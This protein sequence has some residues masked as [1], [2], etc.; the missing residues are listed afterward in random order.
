M[1]RA[2]SVDVAGVSLVAGNARLP[3]VIHNAQAVWQ[4]FNIPWPLYKGADRPLNRELVTA[5]SVLGARGMRSRCQFLPVVNADSPSSMESAFGRW[6]ACNESSH[7]VLAIGP[8]TNLARMQKRHAHLFNRISRI[9]WMGGSSGPGNH[10]E[11]AEFNA[12]VDADAALQ[13]LQGDVPVHVVDLQLCRR[14]TFSERDIPDG[15]PELFQDLMGGYL[16]I[17]LSRGR[18]VMAIYDP[19]ATLAVID[20]DSLQFES[21]GV[22]VSAADDRAYGKTDFYT[23]R[24]SSVSLA[25]GYSPD[26]AQQCL[27]LFKRGVCQ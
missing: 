5:E 9:V 11:H 15:L 23:D 8:L 22:S 7:E 24:K 13:I 27:E 10:T 20:I 12:A 26:C 25:V 2:C 17:A 14:V 18:Q 6:L 1:L 21:C 4:L 3:Q 16:D 19:V